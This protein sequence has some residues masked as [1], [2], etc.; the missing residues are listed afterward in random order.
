[1]YVDTHDGITLVIAQRQI[2]IHSKYGLGAVR[3]TTMVY[4]SLFILNCRYV[5]W[6]FGLGQ[7]HT[8][9]YNDNIFI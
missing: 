8:S 3:P 6:R 2:Y 5:L 9:A 1:M 7:T 4:K